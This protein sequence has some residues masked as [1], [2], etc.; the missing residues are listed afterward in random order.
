[1][2]Q[3]LNRLLGIVSPLVMK[4]LQILNRLLGIVPPLVYATLIAV[5]VS[6][7][8]LEKWQHG[9][10]KD[11]LVVADYSNK[12]YE[13]AQKENLQSIER[14]QLLSEECVQGREVDERKFMDASKLWEGERAVLEVE[15]MQTLMGRLDVYRESSCAEFAKMDLYS[16]CPDFADGLRT[17]AENY[18]SNRS[19]GSTR[20]STVADPQ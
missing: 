17:R 3:I 14:L 13:F 1:M 20:S 4:M 5:F 6:M 11:E 12:Q 10:T 8:G 7:Y 19:G 15:S 18:H 2:L 9:H 16:V